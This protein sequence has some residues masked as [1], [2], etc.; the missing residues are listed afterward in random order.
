MTAN[1]DE[2]R[3]RQKELKNCWLNLTVED[4]SAGP[5]LY[6]EMR[7]RFPHLAFLHGRS[8]QTGEITD[9]ITSEE[10][11]KMNDTDILKHF[12]GDT[13]NSFKPTDEQLEWFEQ[14][15]LAQE[16]EDLQ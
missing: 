7:E 8:I 1:Y 5:E 16:K 2:I 4:K 12:L 14:C 6:S 10:F 11:M 9:A 3:S 13:E 15:M